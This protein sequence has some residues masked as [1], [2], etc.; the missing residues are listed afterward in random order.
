M[1]FKTIISAT[2]LGENFDDPEWIILD[3]RE[4]FLGGSKSYST[5]MDSH[6]PNAFYCCA[7][8]TNASRVHNRKSNIHISQSNSQ[9][10]L[11]CV[12]GKDFDKDSQI[13]IYDN[14]NNTY[15]ET[16][17][18]Q[19]RT[20]GFPNVAVLQGGFDS[21]KAQKMPVAAMSRA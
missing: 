3:C 4:L 12:I 8:I 11:D 18:L 2:A 20:L 21:W 15:T 10:I 13:I 16:F 6:I 19:L 7:S 5:F 1:S 14:D 9:N 17:W